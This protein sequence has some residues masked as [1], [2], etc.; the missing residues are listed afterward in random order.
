VHITRKH[1]L[2]TSA[3]TKAFSIF[4]FEGIYF[5]PFFVVVKL[6]AKFPLPSL[7][8]ASSTKKR[9]VIKILNSKLFTGEK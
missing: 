4:I 6:I 7:K 8:K 5:N 2:E 9:I 1:T 3:Y